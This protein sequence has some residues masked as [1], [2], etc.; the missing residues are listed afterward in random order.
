MNRVQGPISQR[1]GGQRGN[2]TGASS[3]R[4]SPPDPYE[5]ERKRGIRGRKSDDKG[6]RIGRHLRSR[7]TPSTANE[8]RL[9][10]LGLGALSAVLPWMSLATV[11]KGHVQ[12]V[13]TDDLIDLLSLGDSTVTVVL[14]AYLI[15]F[16]V[17]LL[18][19]S[20]A[21]VVLAAWF[22]QDDAVK[23]F[24]IGTA[25][26]ADPGVSYTVLTGVGPY[27]GLIAALLLIVSIVAH[28][29]GERYVAEGTLMPSETYGR[30]MRGVGAPESLLLSSIRWWFTG[31]RRNGPP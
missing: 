10:G 1:G 28:I 15:G 24:L 2:G 13:R 29:R 27:V 5:L 9:A 7:F 25:P 18:Y 11:E 23:A 21:L 20:S 6:S 30:G 26:A 22:L 12:I 19:A 14:A 8:V 3:E 31:R 17:A 16:A 4:R